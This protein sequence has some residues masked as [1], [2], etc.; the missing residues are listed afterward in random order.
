MRTLEELVDASAG[1]IPKQQ[2]IW[3]A[4]L[5]REDQKTLELAHVYVSDTQAQTDIGRPSLGALPNLDQYDT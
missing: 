2:R 3:Y 5:P 4:S 1:M